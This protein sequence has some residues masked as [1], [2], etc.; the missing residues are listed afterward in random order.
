MIDNGVSFLRSPSKRHDFYQ[1]GLLSTNYG[2]MG[3]GVT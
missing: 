3:S 2:M 1:I